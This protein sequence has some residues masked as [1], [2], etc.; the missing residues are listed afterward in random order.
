MRGRGWLPP[1]ITLVLLVAS[2][3][4]SQ[5]GNALAA[6]ETVTAERPSGGEV[7]LQ[8]VLNVP[9]KGESPSG[10]VAASSW[11]PLEAVIPSDEA[12]AVTADLKR[13]T[14]EVA[15]DFGRR[16][17]AFSPIK[18]FVKLGDQSEDSDTAAETTAAKDGRPLNGV[19][20]IPVR[21]CTSRRRSACWK[22]REMLGVPSRG[23]QHS[24]L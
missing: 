5:D 19:V 24:R 2:F 21:S 10:D 6:R 22:V 3:R 23:T 18:Q 1:A 20:P 16:V 13:I 15:N 17:P 7:S 4:R 14:E 8:L 11:S 12:G 9:A